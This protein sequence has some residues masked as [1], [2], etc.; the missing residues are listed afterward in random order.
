MQDV[1]PRLTPKWPDATIRQAQ[2]FIRQITA[3]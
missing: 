3:E 1:F 2:D